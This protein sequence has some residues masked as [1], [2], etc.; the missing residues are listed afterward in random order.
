MTS[1]PHE[2]VVPIKEGSTTTIVLVDYIK[3]QT[4][5]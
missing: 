3:T 1:K 4:N 2:Y 5:Y